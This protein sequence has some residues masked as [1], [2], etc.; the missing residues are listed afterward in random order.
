MTEL[1]QYIKSYFGV[2]ETN[3][4]NTIVSLFKLTIIKKGDFLLQSGKRCD[5]LCFVE[6][7]LL[8]TFIATDSKEITMWISKK[9][10]FSADISSFVFETVSRWTIQALVDTEVYAISADDYK[11]IGNS[12]SKWNEF[13]KLFT[14]RCFAILEERIFSHLSMTAEERYD[15]YFEQ[16]RELFN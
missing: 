9:G 10:Y 8:R 5:K 15:N 11:K 2:V 12:V 7:G 4:L 3:D 16:N 1:E 13:E 6:T 14:I